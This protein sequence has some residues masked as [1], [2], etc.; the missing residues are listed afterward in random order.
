MVMA[1]PWHQ[2]GNAG[3]YGMRKRRAGKAKADIPCPK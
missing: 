2:N 3:F 1:T